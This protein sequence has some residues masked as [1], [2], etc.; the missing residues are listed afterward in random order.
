[1]N[2]TNSSGYGLVSEMGS[3]SPA[4]QSQANRLREAANLVLR[5]FLGGVF[6]LS[7]I[8]KLLE[9]FGFLEDIYRFQL[10]GP[11]LSLLIAIIL[12][13]LEVIIAICFLADALV[14]GASV[15]A[16]CLSTAFVFAIT[17]AILR[18]LDIYCGCFGIGKQSIG[19]FTLVR[20]II[21]LSIAIISIV[22]HGH[23]NVEKNRKALKQRESASS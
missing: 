5:M 23:S 6:L 18:H 13:W 14:A 12:P 20:A 9:P 3:D 7:G 1:M 17:S 19:W 10:T 21:L 4:G 8:S 16:T 22:V 11:R 2:L 15:L